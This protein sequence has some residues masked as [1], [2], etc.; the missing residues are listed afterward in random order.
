M[1]NGVR[2][3]NRLKSRRLAAELS[4]HRRSQNGWAQRLGLSKGYLSQ[5]VNGRRRYP[6]AEVQQR[7]LDA[8]GLDFDDLFEIE[9]YPSKRP[10]LD[11]PRLDRPTSELRQ[12]PT[13]LMGQ[14]DRGMWT[15]LRD[16]RAGGRTLARRPG[17]TA[18]AVLILALGIGANA[19][20][21]SVIRGVLLE[22]LGFPQPEGL[23]RL[24]ENH[25][26]RG[27]ARFGVSPANLADWQAQSETFSHISAYLPRDGNLQAGD[28]AQRVSLALVSPNLERVEALPGVVAATAVNRSPLAGDNWFFNFAVE[29][30]PL[31]ADGLLPNGLA[32]VVTPG[33]FETLKIPQ[34]AGRTFSPLDVQGAPRVVVIDREMARLHWPGEDPIGQRITMGDIPPQFA[35]QFTF[36]VVGV[37]GEVRHNS[38]ETIARPAAYFPFSQATTGHSGDWGMTLLVRTE[39]A[40][41]AALAPIRAEVARLDP[42]LPLFAASSMEEALA[43]TLSSRRFQ[44][45][46]LAAFAALA[47]LLAAV[48][49][50]GL[51][52]FSV[53]QRTREIG[54]RVALGA[55][56]ADVRR[57]VVGEGMRPVLAGLVLGVLGA[58]ASSRLWSS[59]L[60]GI[61]PVDP[62][63]WFGATTV[64]T[65]V[66]LVACWLPARR[67]TRLE[68]TRA[69]RCD[70]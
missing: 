56:R 29:G 47:L 2:Q 4:R 64:L 66:G 35:E 32:R 63:S 40:P 38:L 42:S 5:L 46:L 31:A 53:G 21:F 50:Y 28:R 23:M 45:R 59:F 16:L 22:P 60:Y 3:R 69:L 7:L 11:R 1:A 62:G 20:M 48:G 52:A 15:L 9:R 70:S 43:A 58:L 17:F 24:D 6:S 65:V 36:T 61:E 26:E 25:L 44:L 54:L 14:G 37:V 10:R 67:A 30:R 19:T 57:L 34:V 49:I 18:L 68:P 39:G 13:R 27:F 33:Y 41:L 51:I 8:L 12:L 55:R